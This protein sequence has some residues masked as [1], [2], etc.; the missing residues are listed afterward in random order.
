MGGI[1]REDRDCGDESTESVNQPP[2]ES[3]ARFGGQPG[4]NLKG[5]DIA[6]RLLE[7]A[8]R[9]LK[10]AAALEKTKV[11][12]HIAVQL[13]K[14]GTSA[15]ANYEEARGAESVADF[16]HKLAV[17]LKELRESRYWLRIIAKAEFLPPSRLE[18][19]IE[20]A[21]QLCRILGRSIITSR[22]TAKKRE[23]A[24]RRSR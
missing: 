13:A 20:E 5:G 15:G 6:E 18:P 2:S 3:E 24:R 1:R 4:G 14:A 21:D 19:L 16:A 7:Y 22:A 17:A 11:G 8:V 9:I 10:V 12:Q 23:E